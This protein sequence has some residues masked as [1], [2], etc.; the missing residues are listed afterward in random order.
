MYIKKNPSFCRGQN[1]ERQFILCRQTLF[2]W[3][4]MGKVC[5]KGD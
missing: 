4:Q 3:D 5:D 2:K 1:K